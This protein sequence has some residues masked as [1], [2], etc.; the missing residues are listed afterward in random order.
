M[1]SITCQ[2]INSPNN[3]PVAGLQ[4]MLRCLGHGAIQ[5]TREF[6]G[7]TDFEGEIQRWHPANDSYSLNLDDVLEKFGER[8]SVWQVSFD[9]GQFF[10]VDKTCWPVVKASF[11]LIPG[12]PW[13]PRQSYHVRLFLGPYEYKTDLS[14][15][16]FVPP[17]SE[18]AQSGIYTLLATAIQAGPAAPSEV[19]SPQPS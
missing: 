6:S 7:C 13:E 18:H 10:G 8:C 19:L 15:R 16:P 3:H 2:V 5:D 9:T 1:S 12:N 14:L 17:P 4:V 11:N